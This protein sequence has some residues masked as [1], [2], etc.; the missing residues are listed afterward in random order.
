MNTPTN[1]FKAGFVNIIGK[2]N[3]GKSTLLNTLIGQDLSV[4]NA[5]A[6]TTRHRI[7][8]IINDTNYQ[9]VFSDTP[10]IMKPAYKLHQ[11]MLDAV[12]ETFTDA[13]IIMY[14]TEMRDTRPDEEWMEKIKM[15][16]VPKFIVINKMDT[17]TEP[18]LHAAID[19]W[20]T[21]NAWNEIIPISALHK[22]N[23]NLIIDKIVEY[24]PE[25]QPYFDDDKLTDRNDRFFVTEIIR[26][27]ILANYQKEIPYSVE[28]GLESYKEEKTITKIHAVIFV[29]RE[30]QKAII[31]GHKGASIK[32]TATEARL[33][34]EEF[35]SQKV[36]LEVTIKVKPNWRDDDMALQRFGY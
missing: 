15:M 25:G 13:D 21:Q 27:R 20:K 4:V 36:F 26:E 31:L 7:K 30:S 34:I 6:Q 35:I 16:S 8:A 29:A 10:G 18:E 33:K 28:V 2:P 9:I 17:A 1:S 3:V 12:D 22:F 11:K 24:L 19:F 14:V 5:K 23:T 32:K